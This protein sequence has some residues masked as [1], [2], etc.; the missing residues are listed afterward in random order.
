MNQSTHQ[1]HKI[2]VHISKRLVRNVEKN[3]RVE[4]N[5]KR[6]NLANFIYIYIYIYIKLYTCIICGKNEST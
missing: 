3:I 4:D 6:M 5:K 1:F 2:F